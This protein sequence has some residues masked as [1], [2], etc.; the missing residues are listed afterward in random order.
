MELEFA[1][2]TNAGA[3]V[4][5]INMQPA[6]DVVIRLARE[7]G[8]I[9]NFPTL[10]PEFD[11]CQ[12][13]LTTNRYKYSGTDV[14]EEISD[15]YYYLRKFV[16]EYVSNLAGYQVVLSTSAMPNEARFS[17]VTSLAANHYSRMDSILRGYSLDI[18]RGTNVRGVHVHLGT[19]N[20][21]EGV[22]RLNSLAHQY[23]CFFDEISGLYTPAR[24]ETIRSVVRALGQDTDHEH[25]NYPL[26]YEP[27]H[28]F[29][30]YTK[31][32]TLEFRQ[33]DLG[34]QNQM[35]PEVIYKKVYDMVSKVIEL[36]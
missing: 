20:Q 30:R 21:L 8:S 32:G 28:S 29:M 18:R 33:F 23:P 9:K 3:Q 15:Y 4:N 31:Y 5:Y 1:L 34:E 26:K 10:K 35:T 36:V 7:T 16:Q 11:A 25:C 13:E 14:A 22:E 12:L 24:I 2:E 17:P 27:G 6:S 19:M